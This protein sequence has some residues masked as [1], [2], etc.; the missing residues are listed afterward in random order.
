MIGKRYGS[1]F[2]SLGLSTGAIVKRQS[3]HNSK[4]TVNKVRIS[5]KTWRVT[6]Y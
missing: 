2:G 6:I 3:L 1:T 5:T 4:S